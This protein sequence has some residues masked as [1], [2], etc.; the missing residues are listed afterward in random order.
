METKKAKGS[1]FLKVTGILMIIFGAIAL[2]LSII[3]IIG[4]AAIGYLMDGAISMGIYYASGILLLLSS[5]AELIA[6]IIGVKNCNKPEKAG[7]CIAWGVIVAIL[8]VAGTIL[9]SVAGGTFNTV[10]L[11]SGLLFPVLFI[12]GAYLNKKSA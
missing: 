5:I 6:G 9:T 3:A 7:T 11:V 10:S 2:I 12:I 1:G 8:C 4:V